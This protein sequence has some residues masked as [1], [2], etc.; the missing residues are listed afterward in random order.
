MIR[1]ER[2]FGKIRVTKIEIPRRSGEP[3]F[4]Y[5]VYILN[6]R[7][8]GILLASC[9]TEDEAYGT[10]RELVGDAID[11]SFFLQT[12]PT[13]SSLGAKLRYEP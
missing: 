1:D 9:C 2:T 6:G 8:A 5:D 7:G 12:M 4:A 11:A 10:I 13:Q 3:E